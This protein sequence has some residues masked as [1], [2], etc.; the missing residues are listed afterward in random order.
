MK[1]LS[2]QMRLTQNNGNSH[3]KRNRA[4]QENG[5]VAET[6]KGLQLVTDWFLFG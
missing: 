1:F 4:W 6:T 3:A 5:E 2:L